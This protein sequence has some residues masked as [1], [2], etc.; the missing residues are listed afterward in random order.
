[1]LQSIDICTL[2]H[3]NLPDS[4]YFQVHFWPFDVKRLLLFTTIAWT[5]IEEDHILMLGTVLELF[6]L[7]LLLSSIIKTFWG[8]S[9]K[10]SSP[11]LKLS[12][13]GFHK[14]WA[15]GVKCRAHPHLGENAISWAQGTKAW[16]QARVNLFKK[17]GR[18]VLISSVEHKLLYEIHPI[19]SISIQ[20]HFSIDK[21]VLYLIDWWIIY[22]A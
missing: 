14:S 10:L 7:S 4:F 18:I 16:S 8:G 15:H 5:T 20:F 3:I 19:S 22:C 2:V 11:L 9:Q 17:E 12:M 1:M 13:G 6:W 21:C